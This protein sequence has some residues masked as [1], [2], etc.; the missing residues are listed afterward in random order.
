M[1]TNLSEIVNFNNRFFGYAADF[2]GHPQ[3]S[4]LF[5]QSAQNPKKSGSGYVNISFIEAENREEEQEVYPEKVIEIINNLD[6]KGFKRADIC[7]LTR[8]KS[9]KNK[10]RFFRCFK[11]D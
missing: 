8:R 4:N 1:T 6:T 5:K 11:R 10:A 7:I 2:L 3:Y 9:E